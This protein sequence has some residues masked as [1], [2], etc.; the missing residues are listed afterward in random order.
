MRRD[1]FLF[2]LPKGAAI[3][4][5]FLLAAL[6]LAH[7]PAARALDVPEKPTAWMTD[8]AN[9]LTPDQTLQLNQKLEDFYKRTGS[10][11]LVMTFPSL[12]GEE[13][14]DYTMRVADKWKVKQDRALML[15]VFVQDHKIRIQ[16][17]YGLEGSVTDA[18][19]STVI[20]QTMVPAFRRNDY[21]GG[22]NGAIDQLIAIVE[23]KETPIAPESQPGQ[24]VELSQRDIMMFLII[25]FVLIFVLGP[26]LRRSGCGGLGCLPFFLPGGCGGGGFGGGGGTTF[27][28]GGGGWGVGG[29]W[30]GGGSSFGGGGASGSW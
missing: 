15:F 11:F 21:Y 16:T 20:N 26:M 25:V 23:K 13:L 28:G 30:G 12:E 6:F 5:L 27:G 8:R 18:M 1:T 4:A 3:A 24:Q 2:P 22:I 29:S 10:Q 7:A 9:I 17:G 14:F 19:A